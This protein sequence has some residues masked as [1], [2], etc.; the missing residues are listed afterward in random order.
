ML[1]LFARRVTLSTRRSAATYTR[2]LPSSAS[3]IRLRGIRDTTPHANALRTFVNPQRNASTK[4]TATTN[5]AKSS[6]KSKTAGR[7]KPGRKLT[8]EQKAALK[9]ALQ[10]KKEL[11]RKK[12]AERAAALKAKLKAQSEKKKQAATLKRKRLAE[13]KKKLAE[14]R[15]ARLAKEKEKRLK[16]REAKKPKIIKPPPRRMTPFSLFV[17]EAKKPLQG[18]AADWRNLPEEGKQEYAVRAKAVAE[19]RKE[20]FNAFVKT[21]TPADVIRYNRHQR[22][23]GATGIRVRFNDRPLSS[24]MRY[25]QEFRMRPDQAGKRLVEVSKAAGEAWRSMT[26][27]EK[28]QYKPKSTKQTTA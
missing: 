16:A 21:V 14:A 5:K 12:K 22:N 20:E 13:K 28:D 19:K 7:V 24:F 25:A 4:A 23:K 10:V 26:Q 15:K 18:V 17:Q 9:Q 8:P 2:I 27:E 6:A 1:S 11:D 3:A